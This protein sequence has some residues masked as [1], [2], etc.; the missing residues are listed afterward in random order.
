MLQAEPQLNVVSRTANTNREIRKSEVGAPAPREGAFILHVL[1]HSWP[2]LSGYAVR[3][4]NLISAQ[5]GLGE[6]IKVITSPLHQV[7]DPQAEDRVLDNVEYLRTFV[8][9][10]LAKTAIE[11]R[12]PPVTEFGVG[13]ALGE[14]IHGSCT[15]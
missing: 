14:R 4:R 5:S 1:D 2:V 7:D 3:S 10:G 8:R 9:T 6:R 11:R 12:G 13:C 15:G